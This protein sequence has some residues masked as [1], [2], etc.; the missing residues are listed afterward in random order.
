MIRKYIIF[1]IFFFQSFLLF[2]T[3]QEPDILLYNGRE[4]RIWEEP[5]EIFFE[6][7]PEKR[8]EWSRT[9][10]WRG[11]VA[12]FE[13]IQNE[14]WVIDI[15]NSQNISIINEI[16]DGRDRMKIDWYNGT[17]HFFINR[18][19]RR[20]GSIIIENGKLGRTE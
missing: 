15:K 16:L 17:L 11:Y 2:A 5:M 4:Y 12:T 10:L 7:F 13:I 20:V 1:S 19:D 6:Q 14:L 18:Q 3:I 8:P 9:N